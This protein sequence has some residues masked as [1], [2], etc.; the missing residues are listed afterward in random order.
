MMARSDRRWMLVIAA[1]L[2]AITAVRLLAGDSRLG[3][4]LPS[5]VPIV[6]AAYC[7]GK[8]AALWTAA[9]ATAL[10]VLATTDMDGADLALATMTRG[11]VFFGVGLLVAELLRREAAQ[12]SELD[13]LRVLREALVPA[14]VPDTPGLD[15]ATAYVAAEGQVAGDFFLVI[16]GPDGRTLLVVGDAV[17]HGVA[18]A[19]RATYA[20]AMLATLAGYSQDPARVLELANTALVETDP[21][22]M[23]FI[24]AV[25]ALVHDGRLVWAS[26]GHP[27][28]WD[29]DTGDPLAI[30]PPNEPLGVS[31]SLRF[32]A[33]T[34]NLPQR[35]GVLLYRDG[36]PEA[37]HA[38]GPG[39]DRRLLGEQAA[40]D[41]LR[42][43]RGERPED[44]VKALSL[45]A[46]DFAGGALA[47]DLCLL[48]ARR[49]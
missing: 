30:A 22:G 15:V 35:G 17:G 48:A 18:A 33:R 3:L 10:F 37:R 11:V 14:S 2:L 7:F 1:M 47:D 46:C 13:E 23:D 34:A 28:P 16:P 5:I 44:V 42:A 29:L 6:L 25:C 38:A 24:T 45:V 40:R 12:A 8:R 39:A 32:T 9:A 20:R 19:R 4:S 36:L 31:R 26:A 41:E 43:H 21:L 49:T 27:E